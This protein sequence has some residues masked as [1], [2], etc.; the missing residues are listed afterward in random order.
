MLSEL[1][2]AVDESLDQAQK[3]VSLYERHK[4]E[5]KQVARNLLEEEVSVV[6]C[7]MDVY[8]VDINVSGDYAVLKAIFR[9]FRKAGW[10]IESKPEEREPTFIT[11]IK[12]PDC[13][14][15]WWLSFSSTICKRVQIGTE[16][17]EVPVYEIQCE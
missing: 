12:K 10:E 4:E 8:S 17:K 15:K 2:A 5:I 11:W 14:L 1:K 7:F 13:E 3:R 6:S 9:A 16:M